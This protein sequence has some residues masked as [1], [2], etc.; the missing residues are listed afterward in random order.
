MPDL[1]EARERGLREGGRFIYN[2][3]EIGKVSELEVKWHCF[4]A[5]VAL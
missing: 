5:R 3:I 2:E 1:E 4:A